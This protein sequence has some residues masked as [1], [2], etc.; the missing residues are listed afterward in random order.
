MFLS[1]E[2]RFLVQLAG[3]DEKRGELLGLAEI[4]REDEIIFVDELLVFRE[5]EHVQ[6]TNRGGKLDSIDILF[7]LLFC[8]CGE[9][10]NVLCFDEGCE[11]F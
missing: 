11:R 7:V 4:V 5:E 2:L 8:F 10:N 9:N 3:R 6:R 1:V